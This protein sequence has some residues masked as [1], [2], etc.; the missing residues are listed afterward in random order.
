MDWRGRRYYIARFSY[1]HYDIRISLLKNIDGVRLHSPTK[2][3]LNIKLPDEL[4]SRGYYHTL[5]GCT[6]DSSDKVVL[7]LTRAEREDIYT[8][9]KE[10]IQDTSKRYLDINGIEMPYRKC[11]LNPRKRCNH[12]MDC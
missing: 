1:D 9:W 5:I 11:D 3:D 10:I 7:E 4:E 12:C 2:H 6:I 8:K